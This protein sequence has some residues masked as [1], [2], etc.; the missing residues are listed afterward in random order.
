[1]IHPTSESAS[2]AS[3]Q[4]QPVLSVRG[5]AK[6]FGPG[7]PLCPTFEPGQDGPV[8]NQCPHCKSVLAV[9]GVSFDVYEGQVLGII[10]ESG[11][12]K[13]TVLKCLNF[14]QEPTRG[15]ATFYEDDK[16]IDWFSLSRAEQRWS[17]YHRLGMVHQNPVLGLNYKISAGGNIAERLLMVGKRHY[18]DMRAKAADALNRTEVPSARMDESPAQFSGGMQQ[19]VQIAKAL[20]TEPKLLLLDE[21]TTGLDVSVQARILDLILELQQTTRTAMIA[22]THDLSVIRLLADRTLVMKDGVIVE[23][24]LT[25]QILEDPRHPFTQQLI[26]SA[27]A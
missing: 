5:L 26:A 24:G 14:E 4:A 23:Q 25:D 20:V 11:S 15:Q 18:G 16:A 12:G 1:M 21:V 8:I 9:Q 13:S 2:V 27:L 10:G 3:P 17:R 6:R 19:R 7:C 22:V